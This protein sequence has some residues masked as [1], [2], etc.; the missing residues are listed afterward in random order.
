MRDEDFLIVLVDGNF[1]EFS[2][3]LTADASAR[4]KSHNVAGF[5]E[6]PDAIKLPVVDSKNV[7]HLE[8]AI[9][10]KLAFQLD[11]I[12]PKAF[13]LKRLEDVMVAAGQRNLL[14]SG[15]HYGPGPLDKKQRALQSF[16]GVLGIRRPK[17]TRR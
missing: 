1:L 14:C 2:R 10:H 6:I 4:T 17:C 3:L 9:R 5:T 11:F 15:L 12:I 13:V 8:I 16:L 7:V